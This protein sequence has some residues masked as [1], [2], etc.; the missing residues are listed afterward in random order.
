[1]ICCRSFYYCLD[2]KKENYN[3]IAFITFDFKCYIGGFFKYITNKN[4]VQGIRERIHFRSHHGRIFF[5][6]QNELFDTFFY[7]FNILHFFFT[8]LT[9]YILFDTFLI[10]NAI[11]AGF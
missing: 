10:L 5:C 11:S 8:F 2:V 7:I 9:F 6:D 4:S 3:L 1:M